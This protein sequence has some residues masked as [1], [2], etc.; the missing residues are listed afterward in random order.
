MKLY[1]AREMR[2]ADSAASDAGIPLLLLMEEAG[3]AAAQAALDHFTQPTPILVLCGKGNNGGDGYVAARHL[4]RTRRVGVLELS[5]APTSDEADTMRRTLLAHGLTPNTLN[6]EALEAAL[7]ERPL[8]LD[9][10]FG[11]GLTR[12]LEG[13]M[14]DMVTLLNER[15]VDVLSLDLPS[16][17][18]ADSGDLLG[19]HVRAT[20]TVMFAGAKLSSAFH[21]AKAAFGS[22]EIADIGIPD[23]LLEAQSKVSV[24]T[25]ETVRAELPTRN[26]DTQKYEVGTVLVIAGSSRYLGAAEMACRAALRGGAGLVTLAAEGSFPATWPEFIHER[27]EWDASPLETLADIGTNRAQVRLIGP[28]LDPRADE[29]LPR[30]IALSDAPT[31]L[32]A[33]ALKGSAAWYEAVRG[34]G[35]CVLTPHTG[36]ASKLLATETRDVKRDPLGAARQLSE[37]AGAVVVLKGATTII[38]AP[39]GRTAVHEGGHPGMA[40]GGTGDVLAGLLAAWCKDASSIFERACA[41]VFVHAR[42]GTLAAKQY[43]D[44]LIA[45]DLIERI[46]QAWLELR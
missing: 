13:E 7:Q 41:S 18:S 33:G 5:P 10:L 44:G 32:D 11:S 38:A 26:A 40:T 24:V 9:A 29:L 3:R 17:L 37:R 39:D 25:A 35:R 20:R 27:L 2:A 19:T 16:G 15:R 42:A 14:A 28:G 1:S 45:T 12:P 22:T 36:E 21:P 31:V 34:H 30:L 8:V 23:A 4:L 43:S 6:P 46:P